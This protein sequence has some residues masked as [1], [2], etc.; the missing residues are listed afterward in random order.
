MMDSIIPKDHSYYQHKEDYLNC[1]IYASRKMRRFYYNW[2]E[3]QRPR[4]EKLEA[5]QAKAVEEE[6]EMHVEIAQMQRAKSQQRLQRRKLQRNLV[7]YIQL[8][9]LSKQRE[10]PDNVHV[11]SATSLFTDTL[12]RHLSMKKDQNMWNLL[13]DIPACR[14]RKLLPRKEMEQDRGKH[15]VEAAEAL[16]QRLITATPQSSAPENQRTQLLSRHQQVAKV[17]CT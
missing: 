14:L 3:A 15:H 10:L 17:S 9:T 16:Q 12:P 11:H 6:R 5:E 13:E 4:R 7:L 1:S 2:R 8:E